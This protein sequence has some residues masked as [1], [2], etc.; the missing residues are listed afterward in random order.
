MA[1]KKILHF[2]DPYF[3]YGYLSLKTI[4]TLD[5]PNQLGS[6]PRKNRAAFNNGGNSKLDVPESLVSRINFRTRSRFRSTTAPV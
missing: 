3:T 5:A 1:T 6:I 4:H 2:A